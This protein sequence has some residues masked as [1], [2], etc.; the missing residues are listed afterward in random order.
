[1][2]RK[3]KIKVNSFTSVPYEIK[4]GVPQGAVL[5][6]L[7]F[8]ISINDV[9]LYSNNKNKHSLLFEDD[10]MYMKTFKKINSQTEKELNKQLSSLESWLNNWR[11]KTPYFPIIKK[12]E[13]KG[14]KVLI[15]N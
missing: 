9:P 1:M 6:P 11:L 10:L 7:I 14:K 5:S 12:Q 3:F 2:N 8:S 15:K 13:I 4:C